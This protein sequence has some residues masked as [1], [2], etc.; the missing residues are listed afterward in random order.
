MYVFFDEAQRSGAGEGTMARLLFD[1][2]FPYFFGL[3]LFIFR[4]FLQSAFLMVV[5][6][7]AG[8]S[9]GGEYVVKRNDMFRFL[10]PQK[11]PGFLCLPLVEGS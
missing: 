10:R 9:G 5:C 6:D 8:G 7:E 3:V 11:K 4:F 2:Y 1:H